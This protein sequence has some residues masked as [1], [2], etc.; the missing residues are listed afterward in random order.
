MKNRIY[1]KKEFLLISKNSATGRQ[2]DLLRYM[3]FID[4]I[5]V[6]WFA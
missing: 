4:E 6:A 2:L 5:L 1:L 3:A